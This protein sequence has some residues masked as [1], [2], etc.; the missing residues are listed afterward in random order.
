MM[1]HFETYFDAYYIC[2][3]N[4]GNR[5]L[6]K[7]LG[8]FEN[9]GF[10]IMSSRENTR[11]IARAPVLQMTTTY[12]TLPILAKLHRTFSE[13]ASTKIRQT[14]LFCPN[15]WQPGAWFTVRR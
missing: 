12:T 8:Q 3:F 7:T 10:V 13:V 11:L 5:P 9:F 6:L 15:K 14:N 2:T 4:Y 1:N